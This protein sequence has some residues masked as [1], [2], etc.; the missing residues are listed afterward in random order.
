MGLRKQRIRRL[1][2]LAALILL[3]AGGLWVSRI[4][5]SEGDEA[6]T[7]APSPVTNPEVSLT[8][9]TRQMLTLALGAIN[10]ARVNAGLNEV[11]IDKSLTEEAI[12]RL[13]TLRL[14]HKG[15]EYEAMVQDGEIK[16]VYRVVFV[17]AIQT[18]ACSLPWFSIGE[19]EELAPLKDQNIRKVGLAGAP[20][21]NRV[22]IMMTW[23]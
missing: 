1:T 9:R 18:N 14:P 3:V 12:Q 6:T 4:H 2:I 11:K 20:D 13:E 19:G 10:C 8:D 17:S 7:P 23:R 5:S 16:S 22:W 21:G 15:N